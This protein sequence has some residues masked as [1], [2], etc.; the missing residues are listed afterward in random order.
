VPNLGSIIITVSSTIVFVTKFHTDVTKFLR[1]FFS[2]IPLAL[3]ATASY[4]GELR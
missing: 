1:I 4:A 3:N 2:K